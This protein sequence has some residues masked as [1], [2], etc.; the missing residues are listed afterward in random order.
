M[1]DSVS[2]C[3]FASIPSAQVPSTTEDGNPGSQVQNSDYTEA[4]NGCVNDKNEL[5]K[6]SNPQPHL[7]GDFSSGSHPN[8][9]MKD[10]VMNEGLHANCWKFF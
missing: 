6:V 2:A 7:N 1:N 4:P 3:V 10:K 5:P 8:G 9:V